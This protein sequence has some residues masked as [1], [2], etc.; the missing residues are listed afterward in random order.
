MGVDQLSRHD[1][2][3]DEEGGEEIS[4]ASVSTEEIDVGK[5]IAALDAAGFNIT[6]IGKLS[7]DSAI[8]GDE[9]AAGTT[10]EFEK[11]KIGT[12]GRGALTRAQGTDSVSTT[13]TTILTLPNSAG[14]YRM[15]VYGNDENNNRFYDLLRITRNSSPIV[16]R[17]INDLGTPQG[18]TYSR[19]S[20]QIQMAMDGDSY[21]ITVVAEGIRT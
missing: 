4:P 14:G 7:A 15:H 9:I 13:A 12:S 19:N 8:L 10:L 11:S 5:L 2:S 16:D 6:G 3:S 17:T 1:H 18:R 20:S 21:N